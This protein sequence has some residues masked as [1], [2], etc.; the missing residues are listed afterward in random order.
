METETTFRLEPNILW[1]DSMDEKFTLLA[2]YN[3]AFL[4]DYY[5]T[6]ATKC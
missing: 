5:G 2:R 3:S 4:L 1:S 6:Y